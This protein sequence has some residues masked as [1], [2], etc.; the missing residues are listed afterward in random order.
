MQLDVLLVIIH[1]LRDRLFPVELSLLSTVTFICQVS[2]I[3]TF[4]R[5]L[6]LANNVRIP[7]LQVSQ[8]EQ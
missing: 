7:I 5:A 3:F 4:R 2:S 1:V 6:F 8:W